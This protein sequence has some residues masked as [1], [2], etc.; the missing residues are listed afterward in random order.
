[1]DVS[2]IMWKDSVLLVTE[3]STAAYPSVKEL[4]NKIDSLRAY[5]AHQGRKETDPPMLNVVHTRL[6]YKSTIAVPL[7]KEVEPTEAFAV[8]RFVPWKVMTGVVNGGAMTAERAMDQLRLYVLD[9]QLTAMAMPFQSLETE[10]DKEPDT[11]KWVT[12]VVVPV[13]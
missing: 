8:Q 3:L 6:T 11:T 2:K 4:Y 13:P 10:R 1:M 12:R 7:D 9:Y 5:I